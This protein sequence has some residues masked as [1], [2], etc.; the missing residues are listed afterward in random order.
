M[1]IDEA[2]KYLSNPLSWAIGKT[3]E[4]QIA[5]NKE[6]TQMAIEALEQTKTNCSEIPNNSD[7]ISRQAAIDIFTE[8]YGISAIGSVFDKYEWKDICETTANELPSIQ[9]T[10]YGYNIEHLEMIARVLQKEDLSPERV[11]EA[12]ANIGGIVAI[13]RDEFEETLRK[14]AEE[15]T[16]N[17]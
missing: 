16:K 6:A 14:A 11:A 9:P 2:I 7:T 12:L 10:L 17:M 8:L 1:T 4:Q 13:V 5:D 15:C 3:L